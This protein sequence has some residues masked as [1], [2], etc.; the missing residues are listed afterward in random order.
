VL[1]FSKARMSDK[2]T[3]FQEK[4]EFSKIGAVPAQQPMQ[5]DQFSH[6]ISQDSYPFR[7]GYSSYTHSY[8][9]SLADF[10]ELEMDRYDDFNILSRSLTEISADI[11]EVLTQLDGFVRRVDSDIDEF[12]NARL[13]DLI[14]GDEP[15]W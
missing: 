12:T 6:G 13:G 9:Q 14:P 2:V 15:A 5:Y 7:G 10:S 11:T 8:D 1:N 4:H 3:E